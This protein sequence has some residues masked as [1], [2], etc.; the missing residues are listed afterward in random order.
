MKFMMSRVLRLIYCGLVICLAAPVFAQN[1]TGVLSGNVTD[2]NG[3]AVPGATVS[4][5]NAAT[6]A[7]VFT[8]TTDDNGAY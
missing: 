4:I 7:T 1:L 2:Q 3:A 8:G 6:Q 5:T